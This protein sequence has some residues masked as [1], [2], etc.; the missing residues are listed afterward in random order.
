MQ[1]RTPYAPA[2]VPRT[3]LISGGGIAGC[4]LAFWLTRAGAEVTV[5][6]RAPAPRPGGQAVDLRGAAR[7]VAARMGLLDDIRALGVEQRG[8]AW[9]RDDGSVAA[10]MSAGA[11]G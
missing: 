2:M 7:T 3:V 4:A 11:F 9:V 10:R 5:V 1:L 8:I 6:E